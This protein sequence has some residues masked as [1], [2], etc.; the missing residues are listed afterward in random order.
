VGLRGE[1]SGIRVAVH[2]LVLC[3]AHIDQPVVDTATLVGALREI[4]LLA[5]PVCPDLTRG[6]RAGTQFLQL[7][8]FLGCSPAIELEPPLEPAECAKACASGKLCHIRV[9]APDQRI[10]FR[11][12]SRLPAPRCPHCRK[13]ETGWPELLA[14]WHADPRES[15]WK[16]RTCGHSGRLFDLNFRQ[17]GAFGRCFVDIW[18]IHPAEAVPDDA[19][20]SALG[21]LSGGEWKYL[22]LQD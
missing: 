10:R 13:A 1:R 15:G 11:G 2:K 9:T 17:R 22:Y 8:S 7:V 21:Q 14:C 5:G 3:P 6:Y 16:C 18:G 19:L 12:D 20:L 4:G